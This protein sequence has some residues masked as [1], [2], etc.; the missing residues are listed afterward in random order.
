MEDN[1]LA[2]NIYLEAALKAKKNF[3]TQKAQVF[4]KKAIQK[5]PKNIRAQLL[6]KS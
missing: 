6:L 3:D 2:A 1:K 5:D 4:L